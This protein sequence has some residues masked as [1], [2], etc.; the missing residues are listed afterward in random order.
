VIIMSVN[1][2]VRDFEI[3]STDLNKAISYLRSCRTDVR[4]S[5]LFDYIDKAICVGNGYTKMINGFKEME[6]NNV[7]I[8]RYEVIVNNNCDLAKSFI[9][10]IDRIKS[11]A[12]A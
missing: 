8:S 10:E 11:V 3:L 5:T 6:Q 4:N 7:D 12:H 2:K 9:S 1:I